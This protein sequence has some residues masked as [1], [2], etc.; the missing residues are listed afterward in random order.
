VALP[1]WGREKRIRHFDQFGID[2]RFV[3][4]DIEACAGNPASLSA[5]TNAASSC[6]APRATLM[7]YAV[8]FILAELGL[9]E[10]VPGLRV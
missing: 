5:F 4:I 2:L 9:T 6:T 1:M 3:F 8:G 7:K 10:H